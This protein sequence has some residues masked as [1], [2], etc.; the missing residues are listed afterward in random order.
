MTADEFV[1]ALAGARP[2]VDRLLARGWPAD[3]AAEM[4]EDTQVV[5]REGKIQMV[6]DPVVDLLARYDTS[7]FAVGV[8]TLNHSR[9][10]LQIAQSSKTVAW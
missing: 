1:R 4:I 10:R 5:P 7:R 8:L 6:D 9:L 3:V 2:A